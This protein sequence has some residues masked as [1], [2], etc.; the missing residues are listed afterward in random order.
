MSRCLGNIFDQLCKID[1]KIDMVLV[2]YL[3]AA[4]IVLSALL[5]E[6][7]RATLAEIQ[8]IV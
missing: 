6:Q 7:Y 5:P 8:L 3:E 1:V 2:I 4:N